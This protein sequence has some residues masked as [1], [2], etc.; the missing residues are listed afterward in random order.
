MIWQAKQHSYEMSCRARCLS[1]RYR[2]VSCSETP[3]AQYPETTRGIA[4]NNPAAASTG[5]MVKS[6]LIACALL[7]AAAVRAQTTTPL[8]AYTQ[9]LRAPARVA[10]DAAGNLYVTD[11]AAGRVVV[12]DAFGRCAAIRT[13]FA[14]PLGIAVDVAGQIYLGEEQTGSVSVFDAQ[15]NLLYQLGA[16]AGEFQLP[17]HLAFDAGSNTVYVADSR[18]NVIK[19]YAGAALTN[20]FGAGQLDF[21]T[22]V[23]VATNGE[24]FVVD[25]NNDRVQVFDQAGSFL[26]TYKFSGM[27]G[28]SGRKQGAALDPAG[29]LYVADT[30][31]GAVNIYDAASGTPLA[32]VGGFG[33]APGQ[34]NA[35]GGLVVDS[36]NRLCVASINNGRV[37]L[38]GV[39]S[40]VSLTATPATEVVAA[41]TNVTLQAAPGGAGP[42]LFQWFRNGILLSGATNAAL[43]LA[44]I[45]SGD[46]G[47]YSVVVTGPGGALTSGVAQ[48]T[49]LVPPQ[50]ISD[51]QS[52][53]VLRGTDV[54]LAVSTAGSALA[55]Q[56]QCNGLNIDGATNSVLALPEVQAWQ[57]GNYAVQVGNAV[58]QLTS[59]TATLQVLVPPMV[60][61]ILGLALQPD[62]PAV[63]TFNADPGL[64][65]VF[66]VST[67]LVD[68]TPLT[69][70][71]H[72]AGIADLIDNTVTNQPQ[73]FYRLRWQP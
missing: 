73:R 56:W 20:Q 33:A 64:G 37:E 23:G 34:L 63:L 53:T 54:T 21:P 1:F 17:N 11:S 26:R 7:W 60:M 43:A 9:A 42:F 67:N 57:A 66:D 15:W 58:G 61:E 70:F 46:A 49:V 32:T 62:Q 8:G 18:A 13:G 31:Q 71:I 47:G 2:A 65:Y 39:D 59:A 19:V 16:G 55:Y 36:C 38:F 52:Q 25:Q 51:P 69:N 27:L 22:G 28:P 48:V 35:P 3:A 45:G 72:N 29:R 6:L 50:I 10:A 40:F 30:F 5:L 44:N 41:G 12:F 24:V 68:W 14:G 4:P